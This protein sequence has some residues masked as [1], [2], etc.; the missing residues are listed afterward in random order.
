MSQRFC[1]TE[2]ERRFGSCGFFRAKSG[3]GGC[4]KAD[5]D[6]EKQKGDI[7]AKIEAYCMKCKAKKIMENPEQGTTKNGKPIAKGKCPDCGSTICR[8]GAIK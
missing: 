7:M 4:G 8:I 5:A 2:E 1:K 3:D 6:D